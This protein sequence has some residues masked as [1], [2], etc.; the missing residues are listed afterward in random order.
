VTSYTLFL[1]MVTS[2]FVVPQ[3]D[4]QLFVVLSWWPVTCTVSLHCDNLLDNA[5]WQYCDQL[6]MFLLLTVLNWLQLLPAKLK[7]ILLPI[8][9]IQNSPH[10]SEPPCSRFWIVSIFH[11]QFWQI[12]MRPH[13]WWLR[14]SHCPAVCEGHS[15][16]RQA[17][18]FIT[19]G[20]LL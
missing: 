3:R 14:S 16:L 18:F 17:P 4:D 6:L 1:D 9:N 15:Q 19:W 11:Y 10:T 2:F 13:C 8:F 5:S 20:Q 7:Q 12:S